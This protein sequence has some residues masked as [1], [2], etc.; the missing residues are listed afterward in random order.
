MI[1]YLD[2]SAL[3]KLYVAEAGSTTVRSAVASASQ[4]ATSRVAYPEAR[5]AL[6]RRH[7]EGGLDAHTLHRLVAD[8]ERDLAACVVVEVSPEIAALAGSL[9]ELHALR[10]FD[11]LHVASAVRLGA[12]AAAPVQF[13]SFDARQVDGARAAGLTV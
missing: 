9:A 13:L 3:V 6:A 10:G 5:S 7:R 11:A 12:L 1:L 2:T 4:V 8:L